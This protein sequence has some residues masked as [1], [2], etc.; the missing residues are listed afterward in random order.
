MP[1]HKEDAGE[2]G[3]ILDPRRAA[4]YVLPLWRQPQE[5]RS[6]QILVNRFSL[7]HP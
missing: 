4:S 3:A 6:P 5:D 2:S 1:Q 7:C